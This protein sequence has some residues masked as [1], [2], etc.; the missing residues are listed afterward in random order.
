MT[1]RAVPLDMVRWITGLERL[2]AEGVKGMGSNNRI[3]EVATARQSVD[4][5]FKPLLGPRVDG[6]DGQVRA[7]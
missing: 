1:G 4:L 5:G 2:E 7:L 3:N 6:V